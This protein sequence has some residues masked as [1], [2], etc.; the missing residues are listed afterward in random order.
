MH[1]LATNFVDWSGC[2]MLIINGK[3]FT[4]E[5][6][7]IDNGFVRIKKNLIEETGEMSALKKTKNEVKL[8]PFGYDEYLEKQQSDKNVPS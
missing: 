5:G 8:Y 3:I 7:P 2:A 1:I 6:K 4:M